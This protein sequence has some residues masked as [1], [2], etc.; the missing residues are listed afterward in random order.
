MP[1]PIALAPAGVAV[2]ALALLALALAPLWLAALGP[3]GDAGEAADSE[4]SRPE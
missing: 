2:L 1:D 4:T 3:P